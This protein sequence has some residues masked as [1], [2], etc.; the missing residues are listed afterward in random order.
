MKAAAIYKNP[1]SSL[2][3]NLLPI[4]I[5]RHFPFQNQNKFKIVMPV[6]DRTKIRIA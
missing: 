1:L 6:T 4:D 2:Q 3:R 5:I